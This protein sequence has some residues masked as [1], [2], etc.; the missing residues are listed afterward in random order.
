ME[1]TN[2]RNCGAPHNDKCNYCG[3]VYSK[4]PIS[5][6]INKNRKSAEIALALSVVVPFVLL[7]HYYFKKK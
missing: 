5:L 1:L 6:G 7:N 3:T 4:A 2:C